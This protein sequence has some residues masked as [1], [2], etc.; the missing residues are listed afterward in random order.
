[1][2]YKFIFLKY[3]FAILTF[4]YTELYDFIWCCSVRFSNNITVLP[5]DNGFMHRCAAL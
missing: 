2:I 4:K 1:M 5:S 3:D